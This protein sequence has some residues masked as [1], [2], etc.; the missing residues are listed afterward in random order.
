MHF[1]QPRLCF[2]VNGVAEQAGEPKYVPL[3][4]TKNLEI[5]FAKT[6]KR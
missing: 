1:I 2:T 5:L 3:Y 6:W 4:P